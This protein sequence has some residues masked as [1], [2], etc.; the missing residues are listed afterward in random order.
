MDAILLM[1][2]RALKTGLPLEINF[3]LEYTKTANATTYQWDVVID[4]SWSRSLGN[5]Q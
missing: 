4:V 1:L 3:G 2:L 5:M